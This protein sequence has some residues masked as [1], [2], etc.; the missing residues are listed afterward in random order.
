MSKRILLR[1]VF[2]LTLGVANATLGA[3]QAR[4]Q[5]DDS[6]QADVYK[7]PVQPDPVPNSSQVFAASV[8]T[9]DVADPGPILASAPASAF[10]R[11]GC[12][13]LNPCA[14]VTPAETK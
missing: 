5:D 12:N 1:A 11:D 9:R 14:V 2:A 7:V 8:A 6:D 4:A 3:M 10:S 13:A